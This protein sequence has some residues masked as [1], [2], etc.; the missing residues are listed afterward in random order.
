MASGSGSGGEITPPPPSTG[1]NSSRRG[2][3][4]GIRSYLQP[5][6]ALDNESRD[7]L[8]AL[9]RVT[10]ELRRST[11]QIHRIRRGSPGAGA[12]SS[13]LT[14]L[15]PRVTEIADQ[16]SNVFTTYN[17]F[18][19]MYLV[20]TQFPVFRDVLNSNFN[21]GGND[22]GYSDRVHLLEKLM[23]VTGMLRG[24]VEMVLEQHGYWRAKLAG[25][26]PSRLARRLNF[27]QDVDPA[28][29]AS[30][31]AVF[32]APEPV[33]APTPKHTFKGL[34]MYI[35]HSLTRPSFPNSSLTHSL[36]S[37]LSL[38]SPPLPSF[39]Q[40]TTRGSNGSR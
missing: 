29:G 1:H 35:E 2:S 6:T 26:Q 11:S 21:D 15:R 8:K 9:L 22:P 12:L 10:V 34:T 3:P 38:S 30:V 25:E 40:P 18:P 7:T 33:E 24:H 37:F 28:Q 4:T 31:F 16:L 14:T 19:G 5:V 39:R 17:N 23:Y 20:S 36:T 32:K 27:N 13:T